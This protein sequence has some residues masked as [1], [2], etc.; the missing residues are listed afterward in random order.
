MRKILYFAYLFVILL[1]STNLVFSQ[2]TDD[3]P[4]KGDW[5][6]GIQSTYPFYGAS[7]LLNIKDRIGVQGIYGLN[8]NINSY[9][10]RLL[11]VFTKK[12]NHNI[13]AYGLIGKFNYTTIEIEIT[14]RFEIK[15]VTES[16]LGYGY[17]LGL[18][19]TQVGSTDIPLWL[20]LEIGYGNIDFKRDLVINSSAIRLGAGLH[21]YFSFQ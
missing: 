4:E 9:S 6:I 3:E 18:E 12:S 11:F 21:Y 13:Y 2:S 15:R 8:N 20:N 10:G 5:G 16:I 7:M 1:S 14:N 17:G 19:Y